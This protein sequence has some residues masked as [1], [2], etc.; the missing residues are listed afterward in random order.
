MDEA[1]MTDYQKW[2]HGVLDD[3]SHDV[4]SIIRMI[5]DEKMGES[6]D[7]GLLAGMLSN[8]GVDPSVVALLNDRKNGWGDDG[9]LT[10]L[11]LVLLLGGGGGFG[12]GR[13]GGV[14]GVDRTVVNTSNYEQLMGA[15]R[16]NE[17]SMQNLATALN[18]D[19]NSIKSALCGVDKSLAL[20]NG[21][22][23]QSIAQCCC[24]LGNKINETSCATNLNIERSQNT[25]QQLLN[26]CCCKTNLNM[27]RGFNGVT[28]G[29]SNLGYSIQ[30]Q[31]AAQNAYLADQFCQIKSRE[32]AREIQALRDK[33]EEA[34][35][36]ARTVS[37][38]AAVNGARTVSGTLDTTSFNGTVSQA[39][40]P[41]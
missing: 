22:I 36:D 35:A 28:N 6:Y 1:Q 5:G 23:K 18:C 38:I 8:R 14:A 33:L 37:I 2:E 40:F 24:S 17:L 11:F 19:I 21:D 13:D 16:G 20:S 15:I 34:R 7:S 3:I 39:T 30:S 10:L 29:L 41:V 4:D 27:E 32:D 31:F 25:L 9:M 26:E 12:Y